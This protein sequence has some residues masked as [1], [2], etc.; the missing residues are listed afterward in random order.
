TSTRSARCF[1]VL[2]SQRPQP[3]L[4]RNCGGSWTVLHRG[5]GAGIFWFLFTPCR[6]RARALFALSRRRRALHLDSRSLRGIFRLYGSL[7]L[8]DEQP[9]LLWSG[10]LF[11]RQQFALCLSSR[12]PSC[13]FEYLFP[14]IHDG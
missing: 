9:A 1:S 10:A 6:L 13:R 14:A 2:Y 4:D 3:A 11:C 8:L 12:Q 5:L 7:D